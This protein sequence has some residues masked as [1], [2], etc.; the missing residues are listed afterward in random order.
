MEAHL[1]SR[2]GSQLLC[3]QILHFYNEIVRQPK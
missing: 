3:E 1:L 2:L